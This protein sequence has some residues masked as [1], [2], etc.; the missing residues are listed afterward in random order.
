MDTITVIG[1]LN[2][3]LVVQASRYPL[4]GE[5]LAGTGFHMLPGGKGANQAMAACLAGANTNMI[6]CVGQDPFGKILI[7]SLSQAGVN[8][9]GVQEL[10]GVSTGIATILVEENGENRIIIVPGA[11]DRVTSS[12]LENEWRRIACSSMVILQHEIPLSS[13]HAIIKHCQ[14]ERI[15]VVFNPAPI[16]SIQE[17]ILAAIDTLI[18]NETEASALTRIN[19]RG[20]QTAF[21]AARALLKN[22][23]QTII[24]TLGKDGAVLVDQKSE[25][26]QP[27]YAVKAVDTTAAGDTFVGSYA[28][29]ILE[30]KTAKDSLAYAAAASAIAVTRL[31]AQAS[32]P[33]REEVMHF[34][35]TNVQA[36]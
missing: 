29:M 1:S 30:G 34:L 2:M 22:K 36:L 32:I 12:I 26:H 3:D 19:C 21:Q 27:A 33:N 15:P 4:S 9:D 6:G 17:E 13:V 35:Q 25:I 20:T 11:N 23:T 7:D 18:L 14:I 5:T 28:A 16:Y 8:V 10:T 31:G 24:I